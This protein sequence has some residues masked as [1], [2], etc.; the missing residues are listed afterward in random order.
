MKAAETFSF[1]APPPT[2]R[3]LAGSFPYNFIISIVAIAN[4][5]PLTMHPIEPFSFIYARSCLL[6]SISAGSSSFRS[7]SSKIS[8]LLKSA[9]SSKFIFASRHINFSSFE[10]IRGFIS[11]KLQSLSWRILFKD[12]ISLL[13]TFFCCSFKLKGSIILLTLSSFTFSAISTF[14]VIIFSGVSLATFSIS[15]PPSVQ[16]I[17]AIFELSLSTKQER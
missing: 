11:I 4:P 6:A 15:I 1:V 10:I 3:K 8:G 9:L 16:L 2:S 14:V 5:A 7:L 17:N 13:A 12:C